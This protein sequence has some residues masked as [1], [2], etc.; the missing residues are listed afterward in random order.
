MCAPQ[1][2]W[3][4]LNKFDFVRKFAILIA[5]SKSFQHSVFTIRAE[6]SVGLYLD[7][8]PVG[9]WAFRD[10]M[11]LAASNTSSLLAMRHSVLQ[12]WRLL[13]YPAVL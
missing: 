8:F 12:S 11:I 7:T 2:Y 1:C 5:F 13:M 3:Q 10:E 9:V 6:I 4:L